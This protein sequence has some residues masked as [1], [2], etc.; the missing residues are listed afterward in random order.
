VDSVL[1][2][3]AAIAAAEFGSDISGL[4][5]RCQMQILLES[6]TLIAWLACDMCNWLG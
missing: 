2:S 4:K 5:M 6:V 3:L 1:V